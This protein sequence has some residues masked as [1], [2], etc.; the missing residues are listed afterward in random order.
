V[1]PN[2]QAQW[3]TYPGGTWSPACADCWTGGRSRWLLC[4]VLSSESQRLS[5]LR[6]HPAHARELINLSS[7]HLNT[8]VSKSESGTVVAWWHSGTS[9]HLWPSTIL[10]S[11]L[12][13]S[14]DRSPSFLTI[15]CYVCQTLENLIVFSP[16]LA[17]LLLIVVKLIGGLTWVYY[18]QISNCCKP[19]L[20]YWLTDW[21]HQWLTDC[22][23]CRA[24]C[25]DSFSLL[26]QLCTVAHGIFY[27]ADV[28]IFLLMN[29][30]MLISP[31]IY[32]KTL[33]EWL[34]L[35]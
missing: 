2:N 26:R 17:H 13:L 20:T 7:C 23:T 33:F 14:A 29:Y 15:C 35:A 31:D 24:F 18:Q 19:V 34:S 9:W 5:S 22:W 16:C 32:F 27:M 3:E 6:L 25:W 30:L 28:N 11:R 10:C 12:E 4:I 1:L 8:H 21:C